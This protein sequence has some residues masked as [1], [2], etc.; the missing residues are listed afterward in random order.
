MPKLCQTRCYK[1][2]SNLSVLSFMLENF[3]AHLSIPRSADTL[4]FF[5]FIFQSSGLL[6]SPATINLGVYS[7]PNAAVH[8]QNARTRVRL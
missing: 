5:Q 3:S 6:F 4:N 8:L 7:I 1:S 2:L